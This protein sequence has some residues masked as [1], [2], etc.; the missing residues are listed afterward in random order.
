MKQ[1]VPVA[2]SSKN[3]VSQVGQRETVPIRM[4]ECGEKPRRAAGTRRRFQPFVLLGSCVVLH[5][6]VNS[7]PRNAAYVA[8]EQ[9]S[10]NSS[11][12]RLVGFDTTRAAR[13]LEQKY[14][15]S[16]AKLKVA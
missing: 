5:S 8:S 3:C 9:S 12:I 1:Y 14:T 13:F 2:K 7:P 16:T 10:N 15:F 11:A 6:P 4:T